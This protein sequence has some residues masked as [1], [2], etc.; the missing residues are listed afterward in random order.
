ML[1]HV[2]QI[3]K[4]NDA[5]YVSG[6]TRCGYLKGAW[7]SD[8]EPVMGKRYDIELTFGK[9]N[10]AVD[11]SVITVL[12]RQTK[13]DISYSEDRTIFTACCEDIDEIYYLR[14]SF[15]GLEMLDIENN[16]DTI[17]KGDMLSFSLPFDEIGI[18]PY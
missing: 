15:D 17:Q 9:Q 3:E 1:F 5:I 2:K 11:R 8:K 7:K 14:F 12:S 4:T 16:D 6:P 18:F 10:G 13:S